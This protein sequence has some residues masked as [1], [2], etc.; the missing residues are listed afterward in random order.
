MQVEY[1][2]EQASTVALDVY[3]MLGARVG[4]VNYGN[5]ASGSH[6]ASF[7]ASKLATGMYIFILN[8]SSGSAAVKAIK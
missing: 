6:T 3:N 2:L 5:K 7:D 1:N 8:T 4:V